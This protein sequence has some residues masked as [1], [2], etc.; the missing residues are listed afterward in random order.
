MLAATVQGVV[1][2]NNLE[3]GVWSI[4][5]AA[6]LVAFVQ[7][8]T[9]ERAVAL[10]AFSVFLIADWAGLHIRLEWTAW[11][12]FALKTCC[13]LAFAVLLWRHESERLREAR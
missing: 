13:I 10:V 11:A 9:L 1:F 12:L 5:A 8:R 2:A 7:T 4:V 3:L 6:L